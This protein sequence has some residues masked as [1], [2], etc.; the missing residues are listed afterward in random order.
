MADHTPAN[1]MYGSLLAYADS[2]IIALVGDRIGNHAQN[3]MNK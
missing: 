2:L 3:K 1:Q